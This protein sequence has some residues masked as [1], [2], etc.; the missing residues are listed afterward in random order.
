MLKIV[1]VR[2]AAVETIAHVQTHSQRDQG[3]TSLHAMITVTGSQGV[4]MEDI[5]MAVT[6]SA[7]GTEIVDVADGIRGVVVIGGMVADR[8]GGHEDW[9]MSL[10]HSLHRHVHR[11]VF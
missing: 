3:L 2:S 1:C 8:A 9:S 5:K 10:V 4:P 11:T 6:A 7:V